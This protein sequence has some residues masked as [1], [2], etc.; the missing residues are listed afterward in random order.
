MKFLNNKFS[1]FVGISSLIILISEIIHT[2]TSHSCGIDYLKARRVLTIPMGDK[3]QRYL[4]SS[5]FDTLRIHLDYSFIENNMDKFKKQDLVDLKEKIMPK[6]KQVFESMLKVQR[7]EGKLRFDTDKCDDFKIPEMYLSEGEGVDADLVIFVMIDDTGFFKENGVEAAAIH[8]LQHGITRRPVA[9]YI[10]FKPE[11]QV[12]NSTALDYQ[13]WLALH[14]ITH[15]LVM[16]DSLYPDYINSENKQIGMDKITGTKEIPIENRNTDDKKRQ[17]NIPKRVSH[18]SDSKLIDNEDS[19]LR[20]V[21]HFFNNLINSKNSE[22]AFFQHRVDLPE[23]E[24]EK[25]NIKKETN[26]PI[27]TLTSSANKENES[28]KIKQSKESNTYSNSMTYNL[29]DREAVLTPTQSSVNKV[30]YHIPLRLDNGLKKTTKTMMYL[31][32]PKILKTAQKHF[33]CDSVYGVPLEYNGGEGTNGAHWSKRYMNTD[34]M[35]GDS[36]GENLISEIT[37]ALF[38]DSG[39]YKSDMDKANLFLWGKNE[40]CGFLTENCVTPKEVAKSGRLTNPERTASSTKYKSEFCTDASAPVCSTHNIFRAVCAV[41][42]FDYNLTG[43]ERHFPDAKVGGIDRFADRCPIPIETKRG[44]T[45]YGG[46]CRVGKKAQKYEKI[47]PECACFISSLKPKDE[48]SQSS[49]LQ[50]KSKLINK[51]NITSL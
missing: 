1:F 30:R 3:D 16:N 11:L 22:D 33:K 48:V 20:P 13:V 42:T 46:S 28:S 44:Q 47:C 6:T 8:C 34:Y 10:Q 31:K 9:G 24:K 15:V 35:I 4:S 49:F 19:H 18:I 45:F 26:P 25:E 17:T 5:E 37:L 14:E 43:N 2:V 27:S 21:D 40:G 38:E 51:L 32:S 23:K 12:S 7:V 50:I 29:L 41:K 39:W 36:Y